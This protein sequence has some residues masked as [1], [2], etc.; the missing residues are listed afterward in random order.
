L[1]SIE[2][3]HCFNQPLNNDVLPPSL[4]SLVLCDNYCHFWKL[5]FA[6]EFKLS[7]NK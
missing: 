5:K 7:I 2:F 3:G 4:A 6:A 1:T